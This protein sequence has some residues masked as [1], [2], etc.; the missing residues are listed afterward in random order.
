MK[1]RVRIH[2]LE[3]R[4]ISS[5]AITG[6]MIWGTQSGRAEEEKFSM[7]AELRLALLANPALSRFSPSPPQ[8][9]KSQRLLGPAP[10]FVCMTP[11]LL[12]IS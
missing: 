11:P 4:D 1:V 8:L 12:C 3:G 9:P 2:G 10:P 6:T 7:I 5:K